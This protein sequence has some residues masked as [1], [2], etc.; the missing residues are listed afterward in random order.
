MDESIEV[1]PSEESGNVPAEEIA[2][3]APSEPTT[4]E[5]PA[6]TVETTEPVVPI[7]PELF[8]LPDG[9]KVDGETLAK[10]WKQNFLPEFTRK[11]QELAKLTK[12]ELQTNEPTDP[13]ADPE[14]T[15][16]TYEELAAHIEA[17]TIAKLEA[18]ETER[19]QREQAIEREVV[20]Q[21]TEIKTL[22]PNLNE[23]SLFLHANKYGFR[24]LKVAY[25]N[26][27]DMSEIVKNVQ[28]TTAANI[29]KRVDPVSV[30]PGAT[31]QRLNPD[32]F[33]SAIDYLR[34]LKGSK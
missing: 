4:T 14:Y 27:K 9:R 25:Q 33:S 19:V 1:A 20:T 32:D 22:D 10:E 23:N 26:M 21:L 17:R 2:L 30:T 12:S 18:K 34:A 31:G 29:A 16:A 11:S 5:T 7:E 15:F 3:I 13:L 6:E 24:D 8:E 28:K